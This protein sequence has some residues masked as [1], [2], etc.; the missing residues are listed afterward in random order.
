MCRTDRELQGENRVNG[1][2]QP[3]IFNCYYNVLVGN[4]LPFVSAAAVLCN[5][6]V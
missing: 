6:N 1:F 2:A 4:Y 3:I 5:G